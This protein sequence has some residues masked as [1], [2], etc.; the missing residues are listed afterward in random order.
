MAFRVRLYLLAVVLVGAC[1][2]PTGPRTTSTNE[3]EQMQLAAGA[4]AHGC[5][6]TQGWPK[7]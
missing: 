1:A 5:A 4:K 3:G 7:C 2:D 6:D